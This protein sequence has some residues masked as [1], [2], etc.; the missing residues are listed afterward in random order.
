MCAEAAAGR[1][2]GTPLRS[3]IWHSLGAAWVERQRQPYQRS[4]QLHDNEGTER[5]VY[6]RIQPVGLLPS[7]CREAGRAT[8][9]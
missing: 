3:A 1:E 5:K 9:S 2:K 4:L 8:I 6:G 7:A